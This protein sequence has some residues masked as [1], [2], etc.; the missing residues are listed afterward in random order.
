MKEFLWVNKNLP[1]KTNISG[2]DYDS[3]FMGAIDELIPNDLPEK[4]NS[5]D[6]P[7]HGELWTTALQYEQA[8]NKISVHGKLAL[9]G[10]YYNKTVH[11]DDE[12]PIIRLDYTIKNETS[13]QRHFLWKLH[14]ALNIAPGD[15]LSSPASCG[16]VAD[17]E[18]SR[19]KELQE[20]KWPLIENKNASVV[21]ENNNTMDFFYLYDIPRGEMQMLSGN[22]KHLFSYNYD[23]KIFPYQWYFASYGGFLNHYTAILEPCTNMP[24]RVNEAIKKNQC[25]VLEP[26]EELTTSVR[27]F[28]GETKNYIPLK[29]STMVCG[30]R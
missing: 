5:I 1:L 10:L 27:I 30:K 11:L 13:H 16:K 21:P 15:K 6:Y 29:R 23:K 2:A 4:I 19:F 26:G 14:A 20:F 17:P 12:Y 7:D 3:N 22:G 9:C 18:Y 8:G 25:A 28:A 24:M